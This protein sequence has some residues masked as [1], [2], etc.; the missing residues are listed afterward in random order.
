MIRQILGIALA[1]LWTG[2]LTAQEAQKSAEAGKIDSLR[3][4]VAALREAMNR[5]APAE[6]APALK[7]ENLRRD[8]V[9]QQ[10]RR[11][12]D[13]MTKA[14]NSAVKFS[15]VLFAYYNYTTYGTDGNDFSRV[16]VDR[17]YLTAK[18]T[19][20]ENTRLQFTSDVFR[21]TDATK[22]AFYGG[23]AVRVKF[24]F[25]EYAPWKDVAFRLGMI[26]T[27]WQS[28][29]D[30]IWK[31]RVL[32]A[33]V[34]DRAGY[35]SAAD[36]GAAATYTLPSKLGEVFAAVY[37]GAGFS[38]PEADR[39]KDLALRVS[40]NPIADQPLTLAAY[41][42]KG[43]SPSKI[44]QALGKDRWGALASY[45]YQGVLVGVDFNEKR[46]DGKPSNVTLPDTT[47]AGQAI[48][49]FGE[50]KFPFEGFLS[51]FALVWR[52]DYIDANTTVGRDISRFW[53]AGV[54]WKVNDKFMLILNRQT[55]E[56]EPTVLMTRVD[57]V[58]I[59][60]DNRWYLHALVTF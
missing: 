14:S 26:P 54:S 7:Q 33:H 53:I 2:I 29:L 59:D 40:L 8:S 39:F 17:M 50:A 30:G 34:Q 16:E 51:S 22:N 36:L 21:Q 35:T 1:V 56:A 57:N 32:T 41:Y 3:A 13:A 55:I 15:G 52:L 19:I 44:S 23:L 9:T 25:V 27:H 45:V 12:L 43:A 46:E 18:A 42:Y 49:F 60:Y 58:K 28:V 10:L 24:A 20:S 38:K 4:E 48:S 37:N 6:I 5:V 11:D 31:Y 47:L